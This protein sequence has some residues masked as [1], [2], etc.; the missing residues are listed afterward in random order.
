MLLSTINNK[1]TNN[2]KRLLISV[3]HFIIIFYLIKTTTANENKVFLKL[4]NQYIQ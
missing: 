2:L 4:K 1:D 3:Q